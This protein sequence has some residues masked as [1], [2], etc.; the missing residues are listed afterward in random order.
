MPVGIPDY[1]VLTIRRKR[2]RPLRHA[3]RKYR[4][5]MLSF[6]GA[7]DTSL[8]TRPLPH[9]LRSPWIVDVTCPGCLK[10]LKE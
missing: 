3:V 9:D 8:W 10:K 2:F 6:C 4:G 1:L 7:V 5:G